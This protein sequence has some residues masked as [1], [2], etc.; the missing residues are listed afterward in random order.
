MEFDILVSCFQK[1]LQNTSPAAERLLKF[2]TWTSQTSV[3]C[4]TF[5][6]TNGVVLG[7]TVPRIVHLVD[8]GNVVQSTFG[9]DSHKSGYT[10]PF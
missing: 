8:Y 4:P 9:S 1:V 10:V 3:Y 2:G 7:A 5:P 6:A